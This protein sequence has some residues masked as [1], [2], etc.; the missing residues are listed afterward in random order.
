MSDST[1]LLV[2]VPGALL[3]VL[4]VAASLFGEVMPAG[5]W[6]L[7]AGAGAMVPVLAWWRRDAGAEQ[8]LEALRR[9]ALEVEHRV[10][11]LVR[12]L[13]G[14]VVGVTGQMS[15]DLR[16]V[17][18]LVGDAVHTLQDSFNGLNAQSQSQQ[19]VVASLITEMQEESGDDQRL[20]FRRFAEQTDEVLRFFVDYVVN[21]SSQSMKMVERTDE[22]VASMGKAKALLADVKVI[23]DQTNL[24]A[25]NAAIEAARAGEAG[26]GFAVVA[27]EVRKLSKHS[28]RFNDEIRKVLNSSSD[29]IELARAD[30]AQLASK[31]MNFAIQS[32]ARVNDMF[33]QLGRFNTSVENAL[34]DVS[35]ISGRIDALVGDAV[36]S[37]QFEDIVSQLT[38]YSQGYLE[39]LNGLLQEVNVGLE[40]AVDDDGYSPQRFAAALAALGSRLDAF[41]VAS[42]Q[43]RSR[44]VQQHDMGE[45]DIEL[46]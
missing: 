9:E 20:N 21:T 12:Q 41:V 39:R 8:R 22:I 26:R 28:D 16:R 23:A 32:K 14:H 5:V 44:P 1:K 29:A 2:T 31:D 11:E 24:L 45:G 10:G 46:F 30:I 27:D 6:V 3:A 42:E 15:D 18:T 19:A 35:D 13:D 33:E 34:H 36:R 7:L 38:D 40:Q 4:L 17:Q 37:L 43:A 25:L